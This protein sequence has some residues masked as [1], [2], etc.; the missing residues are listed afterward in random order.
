[1]MKQVI[2]VACYI[3]KP[4]FMV[5]KQIVIEHMVIKHKIIKHIKVMKHIIK[6]V[7]KH[8]RLVIKL[9]VKQMVIKQLNGQLLIVFKLVNIKHVVQLFLMQHI[10]LLV[11]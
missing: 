3:L 9:V 7:V 10:Q 11:H 8:I 5:I 2:K 1:M 4:T 6:L